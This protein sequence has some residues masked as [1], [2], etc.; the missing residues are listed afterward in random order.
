M[1]EWSFKTVGDVKRAMQQS[2]NHW[3][4]ADTMRFF[5]THV[6]MNQRVYAGRI[7]VA[8]HLPLHNE[9]VYGVHIVE[10]QEESK[11]Y[12]IQNADELY[13]TTRDRSVANALAEWLASKADTFP[14]HFSYDEARELQTMVR[15]KLTEKSV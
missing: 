4:S 9:R 7:F 13:D 5:G 10:W 3:F 6:T 15:E 11:S 8:S 14:D 12:S 2:G 1:S